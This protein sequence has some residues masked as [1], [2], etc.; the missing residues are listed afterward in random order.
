MAGAFRVTITLKGF[1]DTMRLMK[2]EELAGTAWR[3]LMEAIGSTGESA[4][5]N[6]GPRSS[7]RLVARASHSVQ[8]KLLPLWTVMRT[9]ARRKNYPY[10]RLTAFSPYA[11][12]RYRTGTNPNR[13]WWQRV[14]GQID[15]GV[16]AAAQRA[17]DEIQRKWGQ[18]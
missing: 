6:L 18:G 8:K 12:S 4:I 14:L 5:R 11:Q 17:M 13:G 15:R 16:S 10:P 7:G 9:R 3:E 2:T 1:K